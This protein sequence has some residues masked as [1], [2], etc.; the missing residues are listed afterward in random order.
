MFVILGR[1]IYIYFSFPV[2]LLGTRLRRFE[3]DSHAKVTQD[4]DV[5]TG[6]FLTTIFNEFDTRML[7]SCINFY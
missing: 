4:D 5:I 6:R 3:F 1:R 7:W 2:G